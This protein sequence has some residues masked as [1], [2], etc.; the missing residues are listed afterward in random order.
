MILFYQQLDYVR[1][2]GNNLFEQEQVFQINSII[3]ATEQSIESATFISLGFCL[4]V[5][6]TFSIKEFI[7]DFWNDFRGTTHDGC[8]C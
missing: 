2:S 8:F 3:L 7:N 4:Y 6:S 5:K 1:R